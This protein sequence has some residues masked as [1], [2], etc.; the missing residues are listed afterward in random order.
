M[1]RLSK[2]KTL[3]LYCQSLHFHILISTT[4][5]YLQR[6]Y[7]SLNIYTNTI[8][9]STPLTQT[10][11]ILSCTMSKRSA[12][13]F[14]VEEMLPRKRKTITGMDCSLLT[15]DA[16]MS[17]AVHMTYPDKDTSS[18]E[19]TDAEVLVTKPMKAAEAKAT[20][21]TK[22]PP[23]R[24]AFNPWKPTIKVPP[25]SPFWGIKPKTG[26]PRPHAHQPSA[27]NSDAATNP[28]LWEDRKFR[29]RRG[30]RHVKYFGP[31]KP[32]GADTGPDLDQ[33]DLLVIKLIDMRPKS[34][35]DPTPRRTP[36]FYA[37]EHG[38][39]KDWNSMQAIKALNDRR[40]QAIDRVTVDPPWQ[41][42]E[43]EYLAALLVAFPNASIWELTERHNDRF[44][45]ED[46][47]LATAFT[48]VDKSIGRTVESVRYEYMTYKPAYD[49]GEAPT[50]AR[51]RNDKSITGKAL[52]KSG[53]VEA[54]FGPP[55][56][57]LEKEWDADVESVDRGDSSDNEPGGEGTK[58]TPTP[59]QKATI[60]KTVPKKTTTKKSKALPKSDDEGELQIAK[61]ARNYEQPKFDEN[62][63][64]L[65][66]LASLDN[67]TD[68]RNSP[69]CSLSPAFHPRP[70]RGP[71]PR[72]LNLYSDTSLADV[73][74]ELQSPIG[75]ARAS[76]VLA[77][78]G[79]QSRLPSLLSDTSLSD[80]PSDLD[81]PVTQQLEIVKRIEQHI[82]PVSSRSS[83]ASTAVPPKSIPPFKV[84][85]EVQIDEDYDDENEEL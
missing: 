40:G 61:V 84:A 74:T 20:G 63:E 41:T 13:S 60:K 57:K 53:R 25:H 59:R 44:M 4:I 54:A 47:A 34:R 10:L 45:N 28:P 22:Q 9:T 78:Q 29:F 66:Q 33:E 75:Q 30:S 17:E 83:S 39:P 76:N 85:R 12:L 73:P 16:T 32:D 58:N 21:L 23:I 35:K 65:L 38:K 14:H 55:D 46:Y 26:D 62:E 3:F 19:D 79:I 80:P 56:K 27:R 70:A 81:S 24:S 68:I 8:S 37:F 71:P 31:L 42:I 36:M 82:T 48:F 67:P 7:T 5:N 43:R 77:V 49:K 50:G 51:W 18:G 69:L 64:D 2:F 6:P 1:A 52:R 11:K 15:S 72:T